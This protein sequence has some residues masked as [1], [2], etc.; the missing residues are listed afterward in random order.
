[1]INGYGKENGDEPCLPED[2]VRDFLD[3]QEEDV[4]NIKN[5]VQESVEKITQEV[6][7]E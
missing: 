7:S 2:G 3:L 5:D 4:E 6:Q 1:M